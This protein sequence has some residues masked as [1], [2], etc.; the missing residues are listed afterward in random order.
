MWGLRLSAGLVVLCLA[1]CGNPPAPQS[2]AALESVATV[3]QLMLGLVVPAS[4]SVF[5]VEGNA[6]AEAAEWEKIQASAAML[7]EAA[8]L[9]LEPSRSVGAE[10]WTQYSRDL[11]E[12]AQSALAAARA[13]DTE[14]VLEAG[15][16]IYAAC[17]GCHAKYLPSA[18]SD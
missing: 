15:D 16:R 2:S 18:A 6:S 4:D 9:L 14:K 5:Q 10:D 7:A 13:L 17:E 12:S 3:R 8:K 1:A 11:H